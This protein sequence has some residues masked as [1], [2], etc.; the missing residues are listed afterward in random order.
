MRTYSVIYDAIDDIRKALEG[1]LE[2][3]YKEHILGRAQV[4]QV[5]SIRK[6]GTIAGSLT[7]DGKVVRGSHARL[8]RDNVVVY[9]GRIASIRRF[10]DDA[11]E[12]TQGLECG[13]L[14][15]NFN[16]VKL[17]D[18]IESYEMEEIQPRLS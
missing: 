13:I 18:I 11:K 5:F 6:V 17:G 1:L 9:D 10:K 12:C 4:I 2:P 8:L 3:T 14:I 16:D 7:L 15:E